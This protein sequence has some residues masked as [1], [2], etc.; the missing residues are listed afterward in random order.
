MNKHLIPTFIFT[1]F[2]SSAALLFLFTGKAFYIFNVYRCL[3]G[4]PMDVH[5]GRRKINGTECILCLRCVFSCP[6]GALHI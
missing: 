1:V 2:A 4:C 5:P 6:T 3:M